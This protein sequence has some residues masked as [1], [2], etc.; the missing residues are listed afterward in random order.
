MA[1]SLIINARR[2]LGWHRRL[3]SDASTAMLWGFWIWL[4][5]PVLSA[6]SWLAGPRLGLQHSLAKALALIVPASTVENTAV[7]LFGTSGSLLLW[8]LFSVRRAPQPE[9]PGLPDYARHFGLSEKQ[10]ADGRTQ[11]ICT[12]HHDER[13]QILR[14]ETRDP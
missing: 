3:F 9:S 4:W 10:V 5:R 8:N 6:V 2:E 1:H 13:G 12:V 7:A 14:I 11:Q